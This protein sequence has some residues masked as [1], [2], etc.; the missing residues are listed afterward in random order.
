MPKKVITRTG[1]PGATPQDRKMLDTITS[2]T[3]P[4]S[5]KED[6]ILLNRN[7]FIHFLFRVGGTSPVFSLQ[8]WWYSFITG[9]WHKGEKLTVNDHDVVTLE[10]QGLDRVALEI[11]SSP[12]GI[13]PVLDCWLALVVPV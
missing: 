4:P 8:L 7:E 2:I 1:V 11:T 5:T 3:P 12:T 6:G 13:T 10:V 9:T